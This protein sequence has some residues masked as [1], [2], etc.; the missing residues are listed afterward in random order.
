MFGECMCR[1]DLNPRHPYHIIQVF[2][3]LNYYWISTQHEKLSLFFLG[4]Q[5]KL[6]YLNFLVK[7]GLGYF[8]FCYSLLKPWVLEI[9]KILHAFR[10]V[11]GFLEEKLNIFFWI[12]KITLLIFKIVHSHPKITIIIQAQVNYNS[13][14]TA[15]NLCYPNNN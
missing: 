2:I 14:P 15:V 7:W 11:F 3:G 5:I 12:L 1:L 10:K 4:V 13:L 6:E 8:C 9:T